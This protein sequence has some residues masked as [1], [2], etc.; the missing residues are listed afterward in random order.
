MTTPWYR[1]ANYVDR[2]SRAHTFLKRTPMSLKKCFMGKVKSVAAGADHTTRVFTTLE[3]HTDRVRVG[4]INP[5]AVALTN[6]KVGFGSSDRLPANGVSFA[7]GSTADGGIQ[8]NGAIANSAAFTV[9]AGTDVHAT[10]VT[11]SPW[12]SINTINRVDGSPRPAL[13]IAIE[14]PAENANRPAN[15]VN[16]LDRTGWENE[17]SATV[18]PF[19]RP[20]KAR[21]G[22]GL[23]VTTATAGASTTWADDGVPFILEYIPRS[24]SGV[25]ETYFGDSLTEAAG[26]SLPGCGWAQIS[27][28]ALSTPENPIEICMLAA[29]AT[30]S[31]Q[32]CLRAE[33]VLPTLKSELVIASLTSPN[34]SAPPTFGETI[35]ARLTFSRLQRIRWAAADVDAAFVGL[36]GGPWL[37]SGSDP[38]GANEAYD[39]AS[40]A[41]I[42]SMLTRLYA[43]N[44]PV[45]DSYSALSGGR[46]ASGQMTFLTGTTS[47]GLH[48]NDAGNRIVASVKN[49]L[50][51]ELGL[52]Q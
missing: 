33:A 51:R 40:I 34:N 44:S 25:T 49:A 12:V 28:A 35:A 21:V 52:A 10:S 6:V 16:G 13:R 20:W 26:A 32:Q 15:D 18:A 46:A 9:A 30:T 42:E 31:D 36:M 2:M 23:G 4:I 1:V 5:L 3:C 22:A 43:S 39:T 27:Q 45:L 8:S 7:S 17:G 19:G 37:S 24:G 48:W 38:A 14:I 11:W 29:G 50:W 47:D 41:V